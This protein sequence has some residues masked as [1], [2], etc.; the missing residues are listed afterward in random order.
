MGRQQA[1]RRLHRVFGRFWRAKRTTRAPAARDDR[2][3][4]SG[5]SSP[6]RLPLQLRAPVVHDSFQSSLPSEAS[7]QSK[8][9]QINLLQTGLPQRALARPTVARVRDLA[10]ERCD[11]GRQC[12]A[13][14]VNCRSLL[15][16]S[17]DP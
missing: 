11:G 14:T 6:L 13:S 12:A 16:Y 10:A 5:P 7:F 17:I 9:G 2:R 15:R 8:R 1:R 3:S 4:R